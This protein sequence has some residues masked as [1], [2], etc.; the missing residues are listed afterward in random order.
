MDNVIAVKLIDYDNVDILY[1]EIE[2]FFFL[3]VSLIEG[4]C[5]NF[6]QT[7]NF[8]LSLPSAA[9]SLDISIWTF[10]IWLLSLSFNFKE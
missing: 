5:N 9:I 3:I 4:L 8:A 2:K 10:S 1:I 6:M 7:V